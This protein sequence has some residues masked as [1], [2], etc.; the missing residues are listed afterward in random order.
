MNTVPEYREL[1]DLQKLNEMKQELEAGFSTVLRHYQAGILHR[2]ERIRQA[3]E[4]QDAERVAMESHSLK[5]VCRQ[6]GLMP[7]GELAAQLETMGA[8]GCLDQAEPLIEQLI[9]SSV[10]GNHELNHFCNGTTL[11]RPFFEKGD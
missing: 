1:T 8:S 3:L 2:P 7:M 11:P 5:S 10:Q 6:V 4:E 9:A